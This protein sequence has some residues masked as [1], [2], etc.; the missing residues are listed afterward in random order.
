MVF[1]DANIPMYAAGAPSSH[2]ER[3]IQILSWVGEGRLAA[4]TDAEVFQEILYRYF[5]IRRMDIGHIVFDSLRT[6]IEQVLPVSADCLWLARD[7]A[8]RYPTVPPRDL[9]HV[10]IMVRHGIRQIVS[11]DTDFDDIAE[12]ERLDPLTMLEP[13]VSN[14]D[15]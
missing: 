14:A 10:A 15:G 6:V 1:I 9:L 4:A 3:C 11:A 5:H 2:K 7:L 13:P 8:S 12:V